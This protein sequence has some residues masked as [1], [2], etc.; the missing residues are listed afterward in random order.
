MAKMIIEIDL[1]ENNFK[2]AV[3]VKKTANG[4]ALDGIPPGQAHNEM[5]GKLI[6][7]HESISFFETNSTKCYY[8]K[9]GGRYYKVCK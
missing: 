8:V 7:K 4:A 2:K 6:K 3:K 5:K 9:I 1:E